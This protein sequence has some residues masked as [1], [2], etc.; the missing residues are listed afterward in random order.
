MQPFFVRR[1]PCT[2]LPYGH[3]YDLIRGI[4]HVDVPIIV[5]SSSLEI[6]F[7]PG[8]P[9]HIGI[10]D[11][12]NRILE[13]LRCYPRIDIGYSSNRWD[14]AVTC[15]VDPLADGSKLF[16][17]SVFPCPVCHSTGKDC[18]LDGTTFEVPY[19]EATFQLWRGMTDDEKVFAVRKAVKPWMPADFTP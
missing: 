3:R 7:F 9:G 15:T 6:R 5:E 4:P 11:E 17:P 2:C 8:F 10:I 12:V 13:A 18:A 16:V 14:A 1:C 19:Q